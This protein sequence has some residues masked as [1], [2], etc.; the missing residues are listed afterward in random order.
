MAGRSPARTPN[1]L[2]PDVRRSDD[3]ID[4]ADPEFSPLGANAGTPIYMQDP[5]AA[6]G[7]YGYNQVPTATTRALPSRACHAVPCLHHGGRMLAAGSLLDN[8]P[9]HPPP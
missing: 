7:S 6:P 5:N 3:H 4:P 8:L 1:A 9:S 2:L